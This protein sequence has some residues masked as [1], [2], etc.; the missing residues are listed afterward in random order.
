MDLYKATFRQQRMLGATLQGSYQL[1]PL[2]SLFAEADAQWYFNQA[3]VLKFLDLK[4]GEAGSYGKA[5][6]GTS[7]ETTRFSAGLKATF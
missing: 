1:T 6:A 5:S 7:L 2:F 4:T 3:G